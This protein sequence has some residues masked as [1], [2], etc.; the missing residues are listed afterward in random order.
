MI[1]VV[2][3][4]QCSCL[5]VV[6]GHWQACSLVSV[7][8]DL[9]LLYSA[10]LVSTHC[11]HVRPNCSS[12]RC[13]CNETFMKLIVEVQNSVHV[14]VMIAYLALEV[15]LAVVSGVET[16]ADVA[17]NA[18]SASLEQL[19]L[20]PLAITASEQ[21]ACHAILQSPARLALCMAASG[22]QEPACL[23]VRSLSPPTSVF[24]RSSLWASSSE[25]TCFSVCKGL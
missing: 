3:Q 17:N 7:S 6:G 19:Q 1:C 23:P 11:T 22:A 8:A 10:G 18:S 9:S 4:A 24:I 21:L 15:L 2:R 14:Q 13:M 5:T 16:L 25:F 12:N 20:A